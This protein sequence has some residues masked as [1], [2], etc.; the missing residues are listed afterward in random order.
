MTDFDLPD[1]FDRPV[2]PVTIPLETEIGETWRPRNIHTPPV[3]RPTQRR[4]R[5]PHGPG[6]PARLVN[7]GPDIISRWQTRIAAAGWDQRGWRGVVSYLTAYG[8]NISVA[9]LDKLGSCAYGRG[10]WEMAEAFWDAAELREAGR[11]PGRHGWQNYLQQFYLATR[12]T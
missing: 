11:V 7:Y 9:K 4:E 10:A 6:R 1:I 8:N 3:Q 12:R 2:G 5:P